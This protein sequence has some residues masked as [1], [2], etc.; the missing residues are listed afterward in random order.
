MKTESA[1]Q[2]RAVSSR[3]LYLRLLQYV[4]PYW[5]IFLAGVVTM[6]LSAATEPLF[7]A[8]MK[9]L[10]DQGFTPRQS[11]LAQWAP[12]LIVLIFLLRGV[13]GFSSDYCMAWVANK[14]VTDLRELM[15][16][17]LV[18]MPSSFL[19]NHSSAVLTARITYDVG[20]VTTAATTAITVLI[21][22]TVTVAGLL[23]W[24]LY[25]NWKLTLISLIIVPAVGLLVGK[26]SRRLRTTSRNVQKSIGELAHVIEE[27][28]SCHKVIKVFGGQDQEVERFQRANQRLRGQQ[29]KHRVA[30]ALA[31][32]LT[33]LV[34]SVAIAIVIWLA[35][36]EGAREQATVGDFVSF[37]TAML[38]LISPLKHLTELN[39]P[40][41]KGLA[42]AES[43]FGFI[44]QPPEQDQGSRELHRAQGRIEFDRVSFQY[45][46]GNR[47]ALHDLSLTIEPGETVA[48]VGPSGSGKSTIASLIP[49]FHSP[50]SGHVSID[51]VELADI[52]LASLRAN[53]ALVSQ[54]LVL[55][56]DTVAANI[57]Y[58]TMRGVSPEEIERAAQ[59]ANAGD[60]IQ[61]MPQG[62]D[63]MIGENGVRLSGGQRQR[64]AIARAFLKDA[65]ILIL[66]EATSA[67]DSESERLIQD[68]LRQLMRNRTTLIIAHRLS[69]VESA[70]RILVVQAGR[71]VEQGRHDELMAKGG[72]Y[73]RLYRIQKS[74]YDERGHAESGEMRT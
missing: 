43:V 59:L 23:G 10:M 34:I 69:T 38:L 33:Q 47:L 74:G 24:L 66:D 8:L 62:F 53:I 36:A 15:F 13:L 61:A 12:A 4:R 19:E 9:T 57:A 30:S 22:D 44:D 71:L 25:L 46:A 73:A 72:M 50:T 16:R 64:L 35:L 17:R 18:A 40:L 42:A 29:M 32:P 3:Q 70:D 27:G 2:T 6:V 63:T 54:D 37:L 56:D 7:P 21:R 65:P 48:L 67:L 11:S 49:R 55:F 60:F 68:A 26:T 39:S 58:G 52:K 14:V 5:K 51:G 28:A 1:L 20:G 45:P 41:Q 31:T